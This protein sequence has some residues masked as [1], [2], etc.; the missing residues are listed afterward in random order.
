MANLNGLFKGS[1]NVYRAIACLK[2]ENSTLELTLTD[3]MPNH[4]L[5]ISINF[6]KSII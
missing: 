4:D 2:Q 5:A 1:P 3:I 6:H